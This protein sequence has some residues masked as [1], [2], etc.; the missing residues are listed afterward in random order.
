MRILSSFLLL[1]LFTACGSDKKQSLADNAP[2][3]KAVVIDNILSRKSVREFISDKP[4]NQEDIDILMK[5][6][7][8][9]PSGKDQRPWELLVINDRQILDKLAEELPYAKMLADA[10]M[11]IIMCGDT[12]KSDYWYLDSSL[13]S[14]NILLAAEAMGLGATWTAA[15]PYR[16]RIE[17]VK[18]VIDMPSHILPLN[19]IPVGYPKGEQKAKDKFDAAKVHLN[20][21]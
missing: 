11:A 7:M 18:S 2:D 17:A 4:V 9:G 1:L 14:Q 5:V 13:G 3:K 16:D 20:K 8:A 15:Y 19:V 12:V 6:G 21:W 10:P